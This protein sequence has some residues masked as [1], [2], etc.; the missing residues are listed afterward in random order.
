MTSKYTTNIYLK[1]LEN[2]LYVHTPLKLL[3]IENCLT[4]PS[5]IKNVFYS[6]L[7]EVFY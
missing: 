4:R 2:T 5:L 7:S 6:F 1:H 3:T